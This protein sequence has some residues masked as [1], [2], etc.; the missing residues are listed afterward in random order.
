MSSKNITFGM[1]PIRDPEMIHINSSPEAPPPRIR[2]LDTRQRE[3]E[4]VRIGDRLNFRIEIPEDSKRNDLLDKAHRMS[5]NN[6]FIFTLYS[7][8]ILLKLL[9]VSLH[10]PASRWLRMHAPAS[11]SLMTMAVLLIRPSFLVSPPMAMH[12]SRPMRLSVSPRATVLSSSVMLNIVWVLANRLCANGIW[13]PSNLWV[14][15]VVV[16]LSRGECAELSLLFGPLGYM[17]VLFLFH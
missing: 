9:M 6:W 16:V 2:I 4:T 17:F 11:K 7:H 12:Y 8:L 3:V 13:N 14:E 15:D 5:T 10:V 1:M